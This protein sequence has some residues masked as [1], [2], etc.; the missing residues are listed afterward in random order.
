[1]STLKTFEFDPLSLTIEEEVFFFPNLDIALAFITNLEEIINGSNVDADVEPVTL[2]EGVHYEL[3]PI[4][5]CL[6]AQDAMNAV[7]DG[8]ISLNGV[9]PDDESE[10]EGENV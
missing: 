9:F 2:E 10:K 8:S 4:E 3:E 7:L 6:S 1:M 5:F